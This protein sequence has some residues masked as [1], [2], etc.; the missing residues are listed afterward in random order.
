LK[1]KP[2]ESLAVADI[3]RDACAIIMQLL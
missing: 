2:Q 1:E 3:I